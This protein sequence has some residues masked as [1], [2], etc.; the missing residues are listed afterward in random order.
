MSN[1]APCVANEK[2]RLARNAGWFSGRAVKP[3]LYC[4]VGVLLFLLIA[5]HIRPGHFF[6]EDYAVYLKQSL[7]LL[8]G[9]PLHEMGIRYWFDPDLPLI[10][11]S[12]LSYPVLI[13]ALFALPVSVFGLDLEA[14]K[15][16]QAAIAVAGL[17]A[18]AVA[19]RT[20]G[21]TRAEVSASVLLFV[22]A[23]SLA[24]DV[25]TIGA[26]LPFILCQ[27]LVLLAASALQRAPTRAAAVR[28]GVVLGVAVWLAI[29][30]R[31]VAVAFI[32][33]LV[34]ADAVAHRRVRLVLLTPALVV[35][36]LWFVQS[37]L[38]GQSA[39]YG[40][41]SHYKFFDV[42]ATGRTL[43]W[44]LANTLQDSPAAAL[45]TPIAAA[46]AA[47][48]GVGVAVRAAAGCPIA[49][50]LTSYTAL[51][52][53]LPD[54]D[55]GTRYLVPHLVFGGAFSARGASTLLRAMA[56]RTPRRAG[57]ALPALASLPAFG[58]AGLYALVPSWPSGPL[59]FGA[60]S[61]SSLEAFARV[62]DGFAPGDLVAVTA[63]RSFHFYTARTTIR[64]PAAGDAARL[65]DWLDRDAVAGVVLKH[66][67]GRGRFDFSDCPASP[68]CRAGAEALGLVEVFRN[69]DWAIWKRREQ[70]PVVGSVGGR[71]P[72]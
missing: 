71:R 61:P 27:A 5:R 47:L 6:S 34:L 66:S 32:P 44:A 51:L 38:V 42:A 63:H 2:A 13:P 4:L 35:A 64:P 8:Q 16:F 56:A 14:L 68:P 22:L 37:S 69:E 30:A 7:N 28:A 65:R 31:T 40:Y 46:M 9:R 50:W 21:L 55:A 41:V 43:L 36:G 23:P 19:M 33:A 24:R 17:A 10:A 57:V 39:S 60:G 11:Q 12:P 20:S 15:L 25:N 29:G 58:L 49:W 45:G 70:A 1:T 26:D 59:P 53:V 18:A 62:A 67:P 48:A 72:G 54:F 52:L 3:A